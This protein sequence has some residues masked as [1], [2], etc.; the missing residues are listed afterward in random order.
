MVGPNESPGEEISAGGVVTRPG[1]EGR[2]ILIA[3]QRDWNTGALNLRLPKGHLEPGESLEEAAVREVAEEVGVEARILHALT[4]VRYAFW[5]EA[6][7]RRVPKVV[8]YF[9]MAW[10]AGDARPLDGEMLRT[11]W[12]SAEETERS[13]SFESERLVVREARALLG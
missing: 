5:H 12:R 4:P 8:H 9:A 13:L 1:P 11:F 7:R 3:E 10:V 2:L 6:E